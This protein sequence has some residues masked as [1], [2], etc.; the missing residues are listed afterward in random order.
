MNNIEKSRKYLQ[1]F[2]RSHSEDYF[3]AM[4]EYRSNH[5]YGNFLNSPKIIQCMRDIF[6]IMEDE[7]SDLSI[8]QKFT[9]PDQLIQTVEKFIKL[10]KSYDSIFKTTI[11]SY[12]DSNLIPDPV[13]EIN[14]RRLEV[15]SACQYFIKMAKREKYNID[16]HPKKIISFILDRCLKYIKILF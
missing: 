7:F 16:I 11:N 8:P 14:K 13:F 1:N 5:G 9:T 3:L 15:L 4:K 2:I 12:S 6:L 10:L